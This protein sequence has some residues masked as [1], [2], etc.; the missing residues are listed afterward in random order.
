MSWKYKYFNGEVAFQAEPEIV[1]KALRAFATEWLD[2]WKVSDTPDGIEARSQSGY[3]FATAIFRV[4]PET[5]GT[6]VTV[7]MQVERANSLGL[8][9]FDIGGY[10]SGL[11]GNWLQALPWWVQQ[12]AMT[13]QSKVQ[14]G[15][16][17]PTTPPIPKPIRG[18]DRR[19]GCITI[20][21]FILLS[22]LAIV[23]IV[24]L[25]TGDLN[26]PGD[27][28]GI[29]IHGRWARLLSAI[30]LALLSWVVLRLRK[31]KKLRQ[32]SGKLPPS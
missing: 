26:L 1:L 4:E 31:L 29:T 7:K 20:S 23:A 18:P 5:G 25:L 27:N 17:T 30:I 16:A 24:G 9:M 13:S 8:M 11:I 6:K 22:V 28:G 2:D 10:F 19:K 12:Q 32:A 14:D 15:N 21:V 3:R